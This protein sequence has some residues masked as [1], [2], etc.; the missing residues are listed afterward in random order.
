MAFF[1]FDFKDT[2][3]QDAR[4]LLCS[5]IVQLNNQSNSFYNILLRFYSTHHDGT[6][7]PSINAL[8]Q[9]LEDMVG[10]LGDV[11]LYLILDALDESPNTN[12]IRSS[13]D[14]VLAL[15]EKL[16]GLNEPKLHLCITSR[17]EADIRNSLEPL[18]SAPNRISLHDQNGQRKDIV[19]FVRSVVY[20]DKNMQR[21]RYEDKE[22]VIETLSQRADGM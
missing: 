11:A 18:T 8:T 9:C 1:F 3:K 4:A 5:L 14:Q 2:G 16:V 22:L 6:Q 10:A 19:N 7:Q 17:P 12:G 21:W 20:S 15:V 13:R